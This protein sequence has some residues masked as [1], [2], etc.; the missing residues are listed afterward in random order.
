MTRH[1]FLFLPNL[2]LAEKTFATTLATTAQLKNQCAFFLEG[3]S[4]MTS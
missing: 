2:R 1:H 4:T 3:V